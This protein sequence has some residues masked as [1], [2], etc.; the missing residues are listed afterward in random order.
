MK[1]SAEWLA[2]TDA[3]AMLQFLQKQKPKPSAR[4]LRL[5]ACACCRLHWPLLE[6][7]CR[8]AVELAERFAEGQAT[9]ADLTAAHD[10]AQKRNRNR[11]GKSGF[12]WGHC[13]EGQ[14]GREIAKATWEATEGATRPARA[15]PTKA[16]WGANL[17]SLIQATKAQSLGQAMTGPFRDPALA[18]ALRDIFA[19]PRPAAVDPAWLRWRDG[20]AVAIAVKIHEDRDFT[21]LPILADALEESGCTNRDIL[22]HCRGP[23]PHVP[24]CWAVD[25]V[26]GKE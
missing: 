2:A 8:Q 15:V 25:L 11:F 17:C 3:D 19:Y 10:L 18:A 1:T 9:L 23:G 13:P 20:A 14:H 21:L 16:I 24:G 22:E 4:K 26:L 7:D 6:E 12:L 5:L